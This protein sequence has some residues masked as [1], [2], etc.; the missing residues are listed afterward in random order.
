[1]VTL[2]EDGDGVPVVDEGR[3]LLQAVLCTL[4]S[5]LCTLYFTL[6]EDGDGVPVVD[7]GGQ[8]PQAVLCTLYSVLYLDRGW[9][10]CACSRRGPAAP[11]GC[12]PP[13]GTGR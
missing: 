4:Y 10:W 1:M 5:V 2:I 6:I 11:P 13:P 9:G 12:T 3:Q 7:E 8:L